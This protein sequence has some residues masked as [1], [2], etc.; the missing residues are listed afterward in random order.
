MTALPP[1]PPRAT[2]RLQIH[3]GFTLDDAR[4]ALPYLARLGISHVYASPL[5]AARPGSA[6]GYD[7]IDPS[8]IDP[9]RGGEDGFERFTA[10]LRNHSLGLILDIVP[11]HMATGPD[12]AWWMDVLE[13]GRSSPHAAVFD[14]DWDAPAQPG[15]VLLPILGQP[16]GTALKE[17]DVALRF[18]AALGRFSIE[19]PGLSL[20]LAGA[21][22]ALPL[23]QA[24]T[25]ATGPS[26]DQLTALADL[27]QALPPDGRGQAEMLR[28]GLAALVARDPGAAA[29]IAEAVA[30]QT[31]D[32]LHRLLERQHYRLA[33]WRVAAAEINYRRFFDIDD[34]IAV[35]IEDPD[36]FAATHRRILDAVAAGQVQGLRIDHIDGLADPAGYLA[37]LRQ[38]IDAAKPDGAPLYLVVEKILADGEDLP[39]VWPV[40]GTTGYEIANAIH[41]VQVDGNARGALTAA[42]ARFTGDTATMDDTIRRCRQAVIAGTLAAPFEAL[43]GAVDRLA[44]ADWPWRDLTRGAIREALAAVIERLTAYRSY[45]G[46]AGD[47][48]AFGLES[49]IAGAREALPPDAAR[50]LGLVAELVTGRSRADG[51][52]A[53]LCRFQQLT[54]AVAAKAVEDTAFYRHFP[55]VSLNEVGGT[56]ERFGLPVDEFHAA[57]AR[58]QQDWPDALSSLSTHDH[59]RGADV[60]ARLAALSELAPDWEAG[61]AAWSAALAPHRGGGNDRPVPSRRHEH[62][63]YQ[64]VIGTWPLGGMAADYPD[65]IVA[66]LLKAAREGKDETGWTDPDAAYE[67]G[68]DRF[69]RAAL[70]PA[71]GGAF[72]AAIAPFAERVARVGAV[73]GL[74]QLAMQLTLPGV[75]DLY[76]G[77][78]DWD[79]SLVDP[80][81]RRP[82]DFMGLAERLEQ[83]AEADP[84]ALAADWPDGRIKHWLAARLLRHR[85]DDPALFARGAYAPVAAS[86]PAAAHVVA[87][88][89]SLGDRHIVVAVPRLVAGRLNGGLGLTGFAGTTLQLPRVDNGGDGREQVPGGVPLDLGR[90]FERLPIFVRHLGESHGQ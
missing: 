17:G 36:V 64:T 11:N 47:G 57:F 35:R 70:D 3:A 23:A 19:V 39:A 31:P 32:D 73:N 83:V 7:T 52:S 87:W 1:G 74:A 59:K 24:A 51:A 34:L 14:I 8:R 12:N 10:A 15:R 54:G 61:L 75:P 44:R 79:L 41:A 33:H 6:H 53:I 60:R 25:Q 50:A 85:R 46:G 65:R 45:L 58:R 18:D 4:A 86:G 88:R 26:A 66:Y 68:L 84:H 77:T 40:D 76:Q 22:T 67:A 72:L 2:A 16:Y 28:G 62:L 48:T 29:A 89:R 55:L 63:F 56:P 13:W 69:V 90:P 37:R 38:A 21:S 20:P 9:E 80:D 82:V 49:A 5:L 71:R 30:R 43:V 81:N 42:Y 27:F 78:E